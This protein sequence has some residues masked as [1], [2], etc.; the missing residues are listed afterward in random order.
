MVLHLAKV[1]AICRQ[2]KVSVCSHL[3]VL[4]KYHGELSTALDRSCVYA[5]R[6]AA[7]VRNS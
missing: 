3:V 7:V 1:V 6:H 2:Y 4:D 5:S